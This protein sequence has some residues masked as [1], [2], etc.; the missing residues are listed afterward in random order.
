[1]EKRARMKILLLEAD[2]DLP[3]K[4]IESILKEVL[5]LYK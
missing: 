1:M 2:N 5:Q 3:V 4:K